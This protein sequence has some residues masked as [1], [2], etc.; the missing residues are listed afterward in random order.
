MKENKTVNLLLK[1][2]VAIMLLGLVLLIAGFVGTGG[3]IAEIRSVFNMDE[4]YNEVAYTETQEVNQIKVVGRDERIVIQKGNVSHVELSYYESSNDTFSYSLTDG[5]LS[6]VK[7]RRPF[8]QNFNLTFAWRSSQTAIVTITVPESYNGSMQLKTTNG[9]IVLDN[10]AIDGTI[11]LE[12][13]N[14]KVE[15]K[16]SNA[17]GV[18]RLKT[19]NGDVVMQHVSTLQT[20]EANTT[21]GRV[22]ISNLSAQSMKFV[23]TNGSVTASRLAADAIELTTTNGGV[24][25]LV[26][27][28][29]EDYK[30]DVRTTNGSITYNDLRIASQ[31]LRPNAPKSLRLRTTNGGITLA[32]LAE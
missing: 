3:N 4:Q 22:Q 8:W 26:I 16:N 21:N 29:E 1:V 5:T 14:G 11:N 25:L 31:T 19:T 2:S 20:I 17:T 6:L 12:T 9:S 13:T 7:Q 18:I 24:T 23:T 15:L 10:F 27:G 32:I 28:E 30:V